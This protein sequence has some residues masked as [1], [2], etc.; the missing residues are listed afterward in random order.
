TVWL[1]EELS[2]S[3]TQPELWKR[4]LRSVGL[5]DIRRLAFSVCSES[6]DLSRIAEGGGATQ[7]L[8]WLTTLEQKVAAVLARHP[9]NRS[10]EKQ[11]RGARDVLQRFLR[12]GP[13]GLVDVK[14]DDAFPGSFNRNLKGWDDEDSEA[15]REIIRVAKALLEV[16]DDFTRSV[17]AL[18]LPFAGRFRRAYAAAGLVSFDGLLTRARSLVRDYLQVREQLKRRYKAILIDEFQDTDPVQYE[19]LLYLAEETGRSADTWKEVQL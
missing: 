4:A 16:D 3:S 6:V 13:T 11:L 7:L 17:V 8:D 15:A 19:I 1:D 10:N 2:R 18:L 5:R 14:A 12:S 9:E